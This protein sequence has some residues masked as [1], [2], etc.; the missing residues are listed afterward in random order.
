MRLHRYIL[1]AMAAALLVGCW[2]TRQT[3]TT[4]PA[5]VVAEPEVPQRQLTVT[6]FTATV[7]GISASGQLRVAE[8]SVIW[9]SVNKLVELGRGLATK[10]SVW[11]I[12]PI[13]NGEFA[14]S[15]DDL[16]RLTR[17]QISYD[18]LQAIVTAED[19]DMQI[20]SLAASLG[21][22]M[23]VYITG[24]RNVKKLTFPFKK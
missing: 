19:A 6:T 13:T 15:Y 18:D 17:R 21:L 24:R 10:D 11:L 7:N 22:E 16:S 5:G 9:V 8:D 20:E 23:K 3:A 2:S 14:G 12:A 1:V 4:A